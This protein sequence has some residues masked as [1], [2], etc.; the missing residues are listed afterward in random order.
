MA[1]N[2]P[3]GVSG[4]EPEITGKYEDE[5]NLEAY[6]LAMEKIQKQFGTEGL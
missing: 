1:S 5:A 4:N 6:A 3:P 2:Y